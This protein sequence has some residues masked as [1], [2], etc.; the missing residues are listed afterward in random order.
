[1]NAVRH[2]LAL[3][4]LALAAT[5]ASAQFVKGNEAVKVMPDGTKKVETPPLPSTTLGAPCAADNPAC[6]AS[7]WR[8]VETTDGLREC[9]E[10]Y[11]RPGT[12]RPS[13]Y[14]TEK[15]PRLWIVKTRGQWMQCQFPDISSKCVSTKALPYSAIQ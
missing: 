5:T 10:I 14:G 6:T 12:C 9:T 8:M 11:A 1:M 3:V 4:A 15:R 2:L 13:T 7:G